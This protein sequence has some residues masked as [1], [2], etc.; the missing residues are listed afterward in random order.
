MRDARSRANVLPK[1]VLTGQNSVLTRTHRPNPCQS[2]KLHSGLAVTRHSKHISCCLFAGAERDADTEAE[3]AHFGD[4][5]FTDDRLSG[6]R[7]IVHKT[8]YVLEYV[9]GASGAP[10]GSTGCMPAELRELEASPAAL[11]SCLVPR[12][13]GLIHAAG[14][15]P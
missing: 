7:S 6:Y 5:L 11:L 13:S 15:R 8:Y 9:V 4:M 14:Q 2:C 12:L 3:A 1:F 10:V